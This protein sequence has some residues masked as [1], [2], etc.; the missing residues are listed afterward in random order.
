[1][2]PRQARVLV[3]GYV[4]GVGYRYSTYHAARRE[5]VTGWVRNLGDGRVEALFEGDPD[6]VSRMVEWC[7]R[8]PPG[9]DVTSLE[10]DWPE[11]TSELSGFTIR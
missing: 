3:S 1:M 9:A 4:Q 8:G 7:R 11:T 10:V 2:T 6:A 5:G